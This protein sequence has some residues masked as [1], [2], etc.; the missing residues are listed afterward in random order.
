[1]EVGKEELKQEIFRLTPSPARQIALEEMGRRGIRD[2]FEV[3]FRSCWSHI[4]FCRQ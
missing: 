3:E 4:V 1:L 2:I